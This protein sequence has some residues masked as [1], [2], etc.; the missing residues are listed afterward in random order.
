MYIPLYVDFEEFVF[1]FPTYFLRM[2]ILDLHVSTFGYP[3]FFIITAAYQ[4]PRVNVE[5]HAS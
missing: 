1:L 3:R 5:L 4:L 2:N